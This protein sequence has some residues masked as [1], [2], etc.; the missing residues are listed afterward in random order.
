MSSLVSLGGKSVEV[1]TQEGGKG[2]KRRNA[3]SGS[4]SA[5]KKRE[6]DDR[7]EPASQRETKGD[8]LWGKKKKEAVPENRDTTSASSGP[9][10]SVQERKRDFDPPFSPSREVSCS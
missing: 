5:G 4:P 7:R 3:V 6:R 8:R 9:E 10:K 1:T 2:E